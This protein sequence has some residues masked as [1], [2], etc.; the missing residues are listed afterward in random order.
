MLNSI[1]SKISYIFL[2]KK[3]ILRLCCQKTKMLH[4]ISY[5]KIN[6]RNPLMKRSYFDT[7]VA[8]ALPSLKCMSK[9]SDLE[10]AVNQHSTRCNDCC[11]PLLQHYHARER[12]K[13]VVFCSQGNKCQA[14]LKCSLFFFFFFL[15]L[16]LSLPNNSAPGIEM[17]LKSAEVSC[18]GTIPNITKTL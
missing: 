10:A 9:C 16:S 7:Q 2:I 17:C 12:E 11:C 8:T 13:Y 18:Y 14:N 15:N 6:L 3:L 4:I 1:V 5:V